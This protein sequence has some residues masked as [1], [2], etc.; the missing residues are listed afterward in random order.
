M[1][2][3]LDRLMKTATNRKVCKDD[4]LSTSFILIKYV[5]ESSVGMIGNNRLLVSWSFLE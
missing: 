1:V 5:D 3:H 2:A 4:I